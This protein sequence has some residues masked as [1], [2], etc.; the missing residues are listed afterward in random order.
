MH[1]CI[2]IKGESRLPCLGECQIDRCARQDQLPWPVGLDM[3]RQETERGSIGERPILPTHDIVRRGGHLQ[4]N[5]GAVELARRPGEQTVHRT[6]DSIVRRRRQSWDAHQVSQVTQG[7]KV[8][9]T[10]V[11]RAACLLGCV[12]PHC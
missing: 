9:S 12:D 6:P 8:V 1:L 2:V 7:L 10:R 11:P 4:V 5:L 3:L